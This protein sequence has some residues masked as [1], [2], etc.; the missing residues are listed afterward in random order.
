LTVADSVSEAVSQVL[1]ETQAGQ[2]L[3]L[4]AAGRLFLGH[5]G[6]AAVDPSTVFRG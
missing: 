5:R 1:E 3:A 6:R 2:G 4:S